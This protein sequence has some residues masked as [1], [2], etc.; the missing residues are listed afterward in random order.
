M[1]GFESFD[2]A[3]EHPYRGPLRFGANDSFGNV[4]LAGRWMTMKG[5]LALWWQVLQAVV[6]LSNAAVNLAR[7]LAFTAASTSRPGHRSRFDH[8][9]DRHVL[10]GR[11]IFDDVFQPFL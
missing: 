2:R 10:V 5:R 9:A 7:S 4:E 11:E 3:Q 6:S 1:I 8:F